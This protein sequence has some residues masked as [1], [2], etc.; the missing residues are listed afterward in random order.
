MALPKY[1]RMRGLAATIATVTCGGNTTSPS[2]PSTTASTTPSATP[3]PTPSPTPSATSCR[4]YPTAANVTV[5]GTQ[6]NVLFSGL[7][8]AT[9]DTG[10]RQ[11]TVTTKFANGVT[12]SV[13]V[14][15]YRS[16]ADFVDEVRVNP[17]LTLALNS[18]N[19]NSGACGTGTATSTNTYDG[20]LRLVTV[21]NS[22]G[23]VTTYTEW[24]SS[25]RPTKGASNTGMTTVNV[26]D[27]ATRTQVQTQSG[28]NGS[29]VAV[30]TFDA[31][32]AQLKSAVTSGNSL[33]TTTFTNTATATVCK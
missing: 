20:Q 8:S 30:M 12:C 26:Y 13:Q 31:N 3:T 32:G 25:G 4:T 5:T 9:F 23:G 2:A 22:A 1:A 15:L 7:E 24:D 21:S 17:G 11:S 10:T 19:T 14:S 29:S 18:T 6:G 27:D 28:S 33:T 16:V